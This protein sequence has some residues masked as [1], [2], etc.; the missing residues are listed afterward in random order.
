MES[1]GVRGGSSLVDGTSSFKEIVGFVNWNL[2]WRWDLGKEWRLQSR[3][4]F[5]A[6]WLGNRSTDAA[7]GTVGPTLLL[8]RER[9][10]LSFE[11]GTG[12]TLL[13]R[14]TFP[15]SD[16]GSELQ[17]STFAGL[18]WD[19]AKHWSLGYRFDHISNGG[20]ASPNP[21]LRMHLLS[22][23]YRF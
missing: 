3:L 16:V 10:P 2:P 7:I 15:A 19:L 12:P 23:S 9:L 1:A 13:S 17:F 21:G 11:A 8:R 18:N 4:D 22:L 6:G 20:L 5:S 14:H